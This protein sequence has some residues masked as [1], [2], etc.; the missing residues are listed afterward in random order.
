MTTPFLVTVDLE[1]EWEQGTTRAVDTHLPRLLELFERHGVRAT[2]FATTELLLKRRA[3]VAALP[4]VH[5][6]ASH[7]VSHRPLHELPR[8]E[9]RR[10]LVESRHAVESFGR[11]CAGFRAP[12]FT[13]TDPV[14][15]EVA[16]AG[17]TYDSSWASFALHI[18]YANLRRAKHP[19]RLASG[20]VEL[21]IPDVTPARIPYGLSYVRLF[22]PM[23]RLF[24][25][26]KP[27]L[28]YLHCDEFLDDG[29]AATFGALVRPLFNRNRGE[30]AWALLET[31]LAQAS[32]GDRAFQTCSE[33]VATLPAAEGPP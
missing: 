12:Y 22:H 28:V 8:D 2:F 4:A 25:R 16:A 26:E 5:E 10:E 9:V 18:G 27:Y 1:S 6:L 15:A 19:V 17:Y 32:A 23:S 20:L 29:P 24:A 11:P 21:P 33:L 3:L 13:M 31:L 30:R 14:L 7:G